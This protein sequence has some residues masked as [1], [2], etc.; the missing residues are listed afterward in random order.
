MAILAK[1]GVVKFEHSTDGGTTWDNVPGVLS[2]DPGTVQ[3]EEI[4][5][6][7]ADSTGGWREKIN[8]YID[9][10]E[11]SVTLH[12]K[13]RDTKLMALRSAVGGAAQKFRLQLD[14][15][16]HTFDALVKGFSEPMQVGEK[17]QATMTI[18]LTGEPTRSA[19]V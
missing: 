16:Y 14:Q 8:G 3:A 15:E 10:S 5:A 13:P 11:G 1:D 9:A 4:D 2:V 17:L 18:A 19:V 6:T 12:N 7:D